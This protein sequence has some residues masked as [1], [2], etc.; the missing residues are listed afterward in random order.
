MIFSV[1][2]IVETLSE[3]KFHDIISKTILTQQLEMYSISRKYDFQ[4]PQNQSDSS[5]RNEVLENEQMPN[6]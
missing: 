1:P 6:C 4:Q 3:P 5:P 2:P